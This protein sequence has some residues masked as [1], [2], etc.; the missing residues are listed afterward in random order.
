MRNTRSLLAFPFS[1]ALALLVLVTA[2]LI[3]AYLS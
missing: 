2:A 1:L 3:V